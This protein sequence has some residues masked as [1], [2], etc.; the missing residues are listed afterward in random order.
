M[1]NIIIVTGASSGMGTCFAQELA[2]ENPDQLWI[3]ARRKEKL[4]E[5][6]KSINIT[7][8]QVETVCIA[9]DISGK[10][11]ALAIKALL[12]KA[13]EENQSQGGICIKVLV[14]NA[15]F[16]SYGEFAD[17]DT[18]REMDMVELNC[19]SLTGITGYALPYMTKGC[20]II[21]T[22]SLA[23]FLPL[24]NF[25]VYGASKAYV[26]SF[27]V[28][29]RAELKDRGISVTAL[30]PGPVSTEFANV[31]SRGARKEVLHGK[32]PLKTVRHAIKASKKGKM[33]SMYA[34]K[35]KFKA[36]AS[37]FIGRYAGAWFTFKY[38]KRPSN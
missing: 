24:G 31:A 12:K 19:T 1:K 20:R 15:G 14:N 21:N 34:F 26:L 28:A 33:Y 6:K 13:D 5:L 16:G 3:I 4:E 7:S 35:W 9:Q 11:G 23:S 10:E 30:C 17:T 36:A 8:P 18:E 27:S 37:R 25:A 38:C 22:A 29:L 32:D 2:L